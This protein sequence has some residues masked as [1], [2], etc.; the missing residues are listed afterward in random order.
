MSKAKKHRDEVVMLKEDNV[1]P[2]LGADEKCCRK[3]RY[4]DTGASNH[5]TGCVDVFTNMDMSVMG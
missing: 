5:M 2:N 3:L 4:L 1:N